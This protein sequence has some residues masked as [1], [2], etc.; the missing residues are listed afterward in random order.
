MPRT[1]TR[2]QPPEEQAQLATLARPPAWVRERP[3]TLRAEIV[4]LKGQIVMLQA[5]NASLRG[6]AQ[7]YREACQEAGRRAREYELTIT[8][9]HRQLLEARGRAVAC[10]RGRVE[11]PQTGAEN[12]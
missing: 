8:S 3:E 9:L 10:V 2:V 1:P 11:K 7:G 5:E 6:Q 4:T 12:E